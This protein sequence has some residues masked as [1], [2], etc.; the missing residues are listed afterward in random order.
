MV[1][2]IMT[3]SKFE[4]STIALAFIFGNNPLTSVISVI[5]ATGSPFGKIPPN[6]EEM[7]GLAIARG[8]VL[9]D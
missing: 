8:E 4:K 3:S 1:I 2:R 5:W 9:S 7:L 6:P